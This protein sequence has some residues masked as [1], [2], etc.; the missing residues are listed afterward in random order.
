MARGFYQHLAE[1]LGVTESGLRVLFR[2]KHGDG[3]LHGMRSAFRDW[4][5]EHDVA[6][7]VADAALAHAIENKVEAAYLRTKFLQKRREVLQRWAD[8]ISE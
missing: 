4:A 7:R 6:D 3:T 2:I 1:M 5:A 8:Y